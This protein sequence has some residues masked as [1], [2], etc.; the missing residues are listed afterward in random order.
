MIRLDGV[1][2]LPV[3]VYGTRKHP[4]SGGSPSSSNKSNNGPHYVFICCD[5]LSCL[6][7]REAGVRSQAP[8]SVVGWQEI[9]S[10]SSSVK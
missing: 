3:M 9:V 6:G 4:K 10:V 1:Q 7:F 8:C 5:M 2:N